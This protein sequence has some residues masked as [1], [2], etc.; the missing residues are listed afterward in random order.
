MFHKHS[1]GEIYVIKI[2]GYTKSIIMTSQFPLIS[3]NYSIFPQMRNC[4][5]KMV[6]RDDKSKIQTVNKNMIYSCGRHVW[7]AERSKA[8]D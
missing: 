1:P 2:L 6:G 8:L 7:M 3:I 4:V 5:L